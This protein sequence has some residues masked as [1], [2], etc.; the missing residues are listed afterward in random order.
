MISQ[1]KIQT[2]INGPDG[3]PINVYCLHDE[4]MLL[5]LTDDGAVFEFLSGRE[6]IP[7]LS[8]FRWNARDLWRKQK[9][10]KQVDLTVIEYDG[11]TKLCVM[12]GEMHQRDATA[13]AKTM[14]ALYAFYGV[15]CPR[16]RP[17]YTSAFESFWKVYPPRRKVGKAAAENAYKMA[18]RRICDQKSVSK[19]EAEEILLD[20][21]TDYAK[22]P[23]G[24]GKYCPQPERWL[25]KARY[26]DAREAWGYGDSDDSGD[27]YGNQA[28]LNEF[29]KLY[30]AKMQ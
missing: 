30:G 19:G 11:R 1:Y 24:Q 14:V 25:Q 13:L 22:S 17:V 10:R 3:K 16:K 28:T 26:D 23:Q 18:I 6:G 2:L 27:T 20:A 8:D 7:A 29:D 12:G 21:I 4:Q 5:H 9:A 15:K